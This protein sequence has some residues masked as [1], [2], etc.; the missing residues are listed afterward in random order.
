MRSL[1]VT[2]VLL[3]PLLVGCG[4]EIAEEAQ[5]SPSTAVTA[6]PVAED[7][8]VEHGV[9]EAICTKCHPQLIPVF[10]AKGDWCAA[11][12]FPMSV[13]PIH[14][15]ERGGRPEARIAVDEAP[16]SGTRIRFKTLETARDAGIETVPAVEG[17][18]GAGVHATAT[19]AADASHMAVVNP[20]AV[21]SESSALVGRMAD[22]IVLPK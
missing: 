4:Q 3:V 2:G 5:E 7:M 6:K 9:L 11:H 19:L 10:Q 20:R 18:E 12:G 17:M 15:P 14:H 13:C 16:A 21:F 8:C 1:V 22:C